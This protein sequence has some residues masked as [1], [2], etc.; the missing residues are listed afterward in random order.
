MKGLRAIFVGSVVSTTA[1]AVLGFGASGCS[2]DASS[3][4]EQ[5]S[6]EANIGTS[7]QA[8]NACPAGVMC[9]DYSAGSV[10][11]R[12]YQCGWST[13]TSNFQNHLT[14][15]CQVDTADFVLVG[16][17]AEI[18]GDPVPGALLTT[19][20][21]N[22]NGW[23]VASKDHVDVG[24][25][26][27]R[28]YAIGLRLAGYTATQLRGQV[29][30]TTVNGSSGAVSS[31]FA[32]V[33]LDSNGDFELLLGGG[34]QTLTTGQLLTAS[35]PFNTTTWSAASKDHIV[36]APGIVTAYAISIPRCPPGLGYCLT[37]GNSNW[38]SSTGTGYR[39]SVSVRATAS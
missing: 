35:Y 25:H 7:Q 20:K 33:P 23:F 32:G 1:L 5:L 14:A 4:G 8:L 6:E 21:P 36:S 12:V 17:G 38:F 29:H 31:A 2:M 3:D 19:S 9:L 27:L 37:N 16:G 22:G 30:V 11:A 18:F 13:G 34:A 28:A 39:S 24:K 15:G 26:S 10:S